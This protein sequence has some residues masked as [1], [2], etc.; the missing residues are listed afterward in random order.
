MASPQGGSAMA[1]HHP[2]T[3]IFASPSA[4]PTSPVLA[5]ASR[6][7]S[8]RAM[9]RLLT[10]LLALFAL[11]LPARAAD[12]IR[13]ASRRVVRAVTVPLMDGEVVGFGPGSGHAISPT[14]SVTTAHALAPARRSP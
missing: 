13:A 9:T 11:T 10:L 4:C 14:R 12:Y 8:L 1:A 5:F 3:D 2:K 7:A 6:A